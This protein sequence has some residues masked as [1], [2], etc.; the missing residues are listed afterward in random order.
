[1]GDDELQVEPARIP[2]TLT[3]HPQEPLN[4]RPL[5]PQPP[6]TQP[7]QRTTPCSHN[8]TTSI[9]TRWIPKRLLQVQGY[10]KGK[11]DVWLPR[12]PHHQ[13]PTSPS[14]SKPRQCK[15]KRT[16]CQVKTHQRWVPVP[17]LEGQG[18]YQGNDQIWV[19]KQTKVAATNGAHQDRM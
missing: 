17:I 5:H 15:A 19:P 3:P 6:H 7:R 11:T 2:L 8:T 4:L 18:F 9:V 1:M 16:Q 13:K 12:Q 14:Q 10:F